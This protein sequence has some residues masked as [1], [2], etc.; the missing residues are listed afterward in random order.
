MIGKVI[1]ISLM[2]M[3]INK[4]FAFNNSGRCVLIFILSL[5]NKLFK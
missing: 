3:E 5:F 4:Y 1:A 2:E